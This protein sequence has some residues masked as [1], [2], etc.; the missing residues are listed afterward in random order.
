MDRITASG[1]VSTA[2]GE[3]EDKN[4]LLPLS[5][6]AQIVYEQSIVDFGKVLIRVLEL[7]D[8]RE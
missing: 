2:V 8:H 4:G 3:L 6:I 1:I 5:R 7:S